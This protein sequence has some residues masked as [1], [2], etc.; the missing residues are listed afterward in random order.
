MVNLFVYLVFLLMILLKVLLQTVGFWVSV[1]IMIF[2]T[3]I[4]IRRSIAGNKSFWSGLQLWKMGRRSG[5]DLLVHAKNKKS[6]NAQT[7]TKVETGRPFPSH[8]SSSFSFP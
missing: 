3:A 7:K 8:L 5:V 6:G 2:K 1:L 4:T